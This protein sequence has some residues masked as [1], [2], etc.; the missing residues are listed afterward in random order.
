MKKTRVFS[1]IGKIHGGGAE[2]LVADLS[3]FLKNHTILLLYSS[4]EMY[5]YNGEIA[6]L[7]PKNKKSIFIKFLSIYKNLNKFKNNQNNGSVFISHLWIP[8]ILNCLKKGKNKII[9]TIHG[10]WSITAGKGKA[11]DY[12]TSFIFKR[13]DSV[14]CVSEYMKELYIKTHGYQKNIH[15]IYNG[16]DLSNIKRL[17]EEKLNFEL[18]RKYLVYVAGL[19]P[20]KNHISL[21]EGLKNFLLNSDYSLIIVGDGPLFKEIQEKINNEGLQ[22]K[23]ILTGNIK[24][25]HPIVARAKYAILASLDES[26]SLTLI[27]ALSLGIPVIATDCGGPREIL[28]PEYLKK[29]LP[30]PHKNNGGVLIEKNDLSKIGEIISTIN[31]NEYHHLKVQAKKRADYFSITKTAAEFTTLINQLT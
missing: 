25:P 5:D 27:E 16:I 18:P 17:S 20:V 22:Q 3:Y 12:F 7:N 29:D 13:A 26:F 4:N 8:N 21:I 2:K 1:I 15:V 24:N 19:R 31:E 11:I 6:Y 9:I 30:Y 14:V 28:A 10:R 23:I